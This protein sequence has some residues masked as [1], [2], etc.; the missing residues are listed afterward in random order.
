M[1][2]QEHEIGVGLVGCGQ[3]AQ[4]A[5][6]EILGSLAGVR[7]AA[8]AEPD[9]DRRASAA[10]RVPGVR[11]LS[12]YRHLLALD[13]VDAVVLSLPPAA[14]ADAAIAALQAGKHVYVE[15]PLAPDRDGAQ[16]VLAA[17]QESG[18]VGMLGFNYRFNRLYR[19]AKQVLDTGELGRPV[20]VRSIFTAATRPMP[21]WKQA[22]ASGGGALLDLGSHH[23]D[24]V[25]YLLGEAV[26]E[27]DCTLH[28]SATEDDTATL[29]LRL[30]GGTLVQSLFSTRSTDDD[31]FEIHCEGGRVMVD[32]G[33][34]LAAQVSAGRAGSRR[35]DQLRHL[36]RA[37]RGMRYGLEKHRAP[38]HEPSWR[39]AL[40][41]FASAVRGERSP[42]PDL[43]DGYRSLEVVLA[44]EESARTGRTVAIPDSGPISAAPRARGAR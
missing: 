39:T 22:R 41:R 7:L 5:H 28:S 33:R 11:A 1:E 42:S 6:L 30:A 26:E 21:G 3:L 23:I 18:R 44:A 17:W 8:I 9:D 36:V 38:G 37:A 29:R 40:E 25:R 24:L 4:T 15:K 12:D 32:R 27:V 43:T 19:E 31:R 35:R 20:A 2:R 34:G 10:A 14:H 16:A 13:D